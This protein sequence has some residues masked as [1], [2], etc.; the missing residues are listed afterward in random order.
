MKATATQTHTFLYDGWNL[1]REEI[2]AATP[3]SRSYVW[4]L[5]LSGTLQGAG[6]VGGLLAMLTPDSGLLTPVYDANGNIT[7][8]MDTNG[9]IV[10]HYEYDGFG[11]I[12]TQSGASA[13]VSLFRFSSKYSDPETDLLYYGYRFY[14]QHIGRWVNRDKLGEIKEYNLYSFNINNPISRID[15]LGLASTGAKECCDR[16]LDK[17]IGSSPYREKLDELKSRG[18][19]LNDPTCAICGGSECGTYNS[20]AKKNNSVR[21]VCAINR[22]SVKT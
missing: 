14:N 7:D 3:T 22:R 18:C 4:G 11:N 21:V 13:E 5:D 20:T 2:E 19:I 17:L 1:I 15:Y 10:A 12:I 16:D 8:L 6:G 9:A